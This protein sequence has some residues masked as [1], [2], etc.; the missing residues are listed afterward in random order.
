MKIRILDKAKK[1]KVV[2]GLLDF[3]VEKV[4]WLLIRS[5]SEKIR[6]YSGALSRE[7][8]MEFFRLFPVE[9]AGLYFAKEIVD[10][11]GV[12]EFRLSLDA[13]KILEGQIKKR[14]VVLTRKQEEEWFRGKNIELEAGQTAGFEKIQGYVAVMSADK[15]DFIGT[16]KAGVGRIIYNYLPKERRRKGSGA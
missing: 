7:E 3:G 9:A 12:R 13:L 10:R 1:K 2:G 5:G 4:P 15:K 11:N 16:G 6:A 8:I 14:V